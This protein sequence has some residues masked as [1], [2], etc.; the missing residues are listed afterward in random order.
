MT[1]D[2]VR[3]VEDL[4]DRVHVWRGEDRT[5]GLVPTMGGLHEGHLSLVRQALE[6]TERVI[7]TIFVNPKQFGKGE[8]FAAYPRTEDADADLLTASGANL[9]FA[10]AAP[11]VYGDGHVSCVSVPGLGDM[12]EGEHRP[13]FFTGVATVV[14]KLLLQ[15]LPDAAFFGEKDY[16]QLLVIRRMV[17]D[18]NI[19][20]NI[21][22]GPTVRE[23]DG[24]ALSSRNVY[25]TTEERLIAPALYAVLT[26]IAGNVADGAAVNE[27]TA[28]GRRRLIETG[29]AAVDY[30]EV[31]DAVTL[32]AAEV[33]ARP[34][35]VLAA[36]RLGRTRL[37][38]NVA[39]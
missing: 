7:V 26:T 8:D 16:Q 22:S 10:P 24:L 39:V 13:G 18:L 2:I 27:Q 5:V 29:F 21:C 34:A 20:V 11:E 4:R 23:A 15:A 14:A 6:K 9:L 12:L 17:G 1:I 3:T 33:P 38:D 31:R 30:L 35:R 36:A 37:I 19:P 32:A 28:L 25:L